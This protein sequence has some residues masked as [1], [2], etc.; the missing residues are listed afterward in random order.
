MSDVIEFPGGTEFFRRNVERIIEESLHVSDPEV[1]A[2]I[3]KRVGETLS[4]YRGIPP[5]QIS[6]VPPLNETDEKKL[7]EALAKVYNE[8][9][10]IFAMELVKEICIL[11]AR[12]CRVEHGQ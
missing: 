12:L 9:V 11:Q 7:S 5:L 8:K 4:R 6:L 1:K 3:K 2:C 10:S